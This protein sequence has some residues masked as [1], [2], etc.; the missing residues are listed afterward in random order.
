MELILR[1]LSDNNFG[2]RE[3]RESACLSSFM[4]ELTL[5]ARVFT[6]SEVVKACLK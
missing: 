3:R 2:A 6:P 4:I 1:E 5:R